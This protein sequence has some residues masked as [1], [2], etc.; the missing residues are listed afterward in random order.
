MRAALV[1]GVL[2]GSLFGTLCG[3]DAV[4]RADATATATVTLSAQGNQLAT[5]LGE[6]PAQLQA[7]IQKQ[8]DDAYQTTNINQ[9]LRDFVDATSF[10]NRGLGVDYATATDDVMIGFAGNVAVSSPSALNDTNHPTGGAAANFGGMFG[11]NLRALGMERMQ[12]F[13]NGFYE[14][15]STNQLTGHLTS[16]GAHLQFRLVKPEID[17]GSSVAF[18]WIGIDITSGAEYTK[19][20]LGVKDTLTDQYGIG[21]GGS[22]GLNVTSTGTFNLS[23]Q[24]FTVPLELTTGFRILE[25]FSVYG[26]GGIDFNVGSSTIDASLNGT[27]TTAQAV[28]TVPAGTNVGTVSIAGTGSNTGSPAAWRVLLGG[29]VNLWRLKIF[30]QGNLSQNSTAS[31]SFGVRLV[32]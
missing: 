30:A 25:L 8:V 2:S 27:A 16:A 21:N 14:G 18:R 32:L 26:G 7:Q 24:V 19:W 20:T 11:A 22:Q 1:V 6:T 23:S 28:G 13:M 31:V 4:A 9:F 5:A 15:D 17:E 12:F 3:A 29:Q 10:S